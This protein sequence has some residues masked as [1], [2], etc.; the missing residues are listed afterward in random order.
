MRVRNGGRHFLLALITLLGCSDQKSNPSSAPTG[1]AGQSAA[2]GASGANGTNGASGAG[3]SRSSVGTSGAGAGAP[4]G[5]GGGSLTPFE[6]EG[7]PWEQPAPRA[8]CGASDMADPGLQGLSA[9]VRCNVAVVGHVMVPHFL[10]LAWHEDC[11]YVNAQAG[12]AVIDVSD[13]S[14]PSV[15]ATLTTTGMQSNWES[16]KVHQGRGLLVGHASNGTVLDVYDVSADCKKPVLKKSFDMAGSS[17]HAGDFSPDGL[18]YY[19][20]SLFVQK[21]FAVDL[22]DPANPNVITSMFDQPSHDLFIGKGGNRGYFAYAMGI[23][24]GGSV[25][26][27]DLTDIQARK[28][29]P[30]GTLIKQFKWDDGS[31]TQYPIAITYRGKDY[32]MITDELGSGNC[33]SP[34]MPQFGYARILDISDEQNPTLVSMVKTEAQDPA[35]CKEATAQAQ[36]GTFFGVGTHYCNVD[37]LADPRLL[38]C[39]EW[40]GGVR[41]FDIRNPWRPKEVA[42]FN[43]G[44]GDTVPGLVRILT[45]KRELWAATTASGF[46]VLKF[47][48]GVLDPILAN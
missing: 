2:A 37:R 35:N 9:N 29:N 31:A 14:N 5:G 16:M 18:T 34:S 15:V 13:D 7:M 46:Y 22:T 17:G 44:N 12:T 36:G 20:G 25:G 4:G 3:G 6:G 27:M 8:T 23:G 1:A 28:P 40:S 19:D 32:L 43:P 24:T 33:N 41:V 45:D 48:D 42:Y 10:S 11:A 30:K 38:A 21:V 26:I 39:G 47:A